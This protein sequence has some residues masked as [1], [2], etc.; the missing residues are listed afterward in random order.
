M[1]VFGSPGELAAIFV[2]LA[3]GGLIKGVTGAGSPVLAVPVMAAVF[4]VRVAVALMVVPNLVTNLWQLVRMRRHLLP[5]GFAWRHAV[6]GA[7]GAA[8]GTGLLAWLPGDALAI[9]LAGA[10]IAYV[11]LRLF[12]PGFQI[13]TAFAERV[14]VPVGLAGGI[15]QGATGISAPVAVSFLNAMRLERLVFIPTISAFFFAM[16]VTQLP[17]QWATGIMTGPLFLA[18]I[19][20]LIPLTL[21][22][23]VGEWIA[24]RISPVL[25]DRV[26]LVLLSVL[27]I[28]LIWGALA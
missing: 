13:A 11:A 18:S 16:T 10:V 27:A 17:A 3:L 9:L 19:L 22:M 6:A 14:A 5:G 1:T 23:F 12:R 7:V 15:M 25:F 2:A 21:F 24:K 4:D 28:R 20:A 8:L 26:I